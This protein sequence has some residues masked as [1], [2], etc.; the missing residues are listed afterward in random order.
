M[1]WGFRIIGLMVSAGAVGVAASRK[2]KANADAAADA[3]PEEE[4]GYQLLD[5]RDIEIVDADRAM[6]WAYDLGRRS[7]MAELLAE[8]GGGCPLD[9]EILKA[10]NAS[11]PDKLRFMYDLARSA[12]QGHV[13]AGAS[14]VFANLALAQ[15]RGEAGKIGVNVGAWPQGVA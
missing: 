2:Q 14:P 15:I 3:P 9:Q 5:C 6:Q 4:R 13:Q 8:L 10:L 7:S 12:L 1:G 11:G